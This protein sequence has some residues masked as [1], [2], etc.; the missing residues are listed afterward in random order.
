VFQWGKSFGV[1]GYFRIV[2]GRNICDLGTSGSYVPDFDFDKPG[3]SC[4][5]TKSGKTATCY[6]VGYCKTLG[7]DFVA[8]PRKE[9]PTGQTCCVPWDMKRQADATN[10]LL[11]AS[12]PAEPEAK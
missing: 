9:C 1:N 7:T 3:P 11:Q 5:V 6:T 10:D 8:L 2:K 4:P 12:W